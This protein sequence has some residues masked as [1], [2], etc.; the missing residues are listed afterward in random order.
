MSREI[1]DVGAA[2]IKVPLRLVF[3]YTLG[4]T[5]SSVAIVKILV[6]T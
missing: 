2:E 1:D 5:R 4:P 3:L 6:N